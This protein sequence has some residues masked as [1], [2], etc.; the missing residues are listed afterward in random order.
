[1]STSSVRSGWL[2]KACLHSLFSLTELC[3]SHASVDPVL[4]CH[5]YSSCVS[6]A[7]GKSV[8]EWSIC[9]VRQ[10]LLHNAMT[11]IT[12]VI[13][14][15]VLNFRFPLLR[16]VEAEILHNITAFT[17]HASVQVIE[18][19][20]VPILCDCLESNVPDVQVSWAYW[21]R[22]ICFFLSFIG[23]AITFGDPVSREGQ[24][25]SK[26]YLAFPL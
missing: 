21:I 26:I 5:I 22:P 9:G 25:I 13:I 12:V 14:L 11:T 15:I 6:I 18:Q 24:R 3:S 7:I 1:M 8:T 20:F 17:K 4:V 19:F 2:E 10:A 23:A 16:Q